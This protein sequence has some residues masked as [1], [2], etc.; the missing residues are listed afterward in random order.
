MPV[1]VMPPAAPPNWPYPLVAYRTAPSYYLDD[2]EPADVDVSGVHKHRHSIFYEG[3]TVALRIQKNTPTNWVVKAVLESVYGGVTSQVVTFG[4]FAPGHYRVYYTGSLTDP[5]YGPAYGVTHFSVLRLHPNFLDMRSLDSRYAVF[6]WKPNGYGRVDADVDAGTNTIGNSVGGFDMIL[7]NALSMP[8]GRTPIE[9]NWNQGPNGAFDMDGLFNNGAG[10]VDI[11]GRYTETKNFLAGVVDDY[12][13]HSKSSWADPHRQRDMWVNYPLYS[14]LYDS[15]A[16]PQSPAGLDWATIM[17]LN[18]SIDTSKLFIK[19]TAGTSSGRKITVYYPDTSTIVETYDNLDLQTQAVAAIN[20][21]GGSPT[22]TASTYIRIFGSDGAS[23]GVLST[24]TAFHESGWQ[25]NSDQLR[26]L[27]ANY[28]PLGCLRVEGPANEPGLSAFIAHAIMIADQSAQQG[29]SRVR[30]MGTCPVDIYHLTTPPNNRWTDVFDYWASVSY[31]P[32]VLSFHDYNSYVGDINLL[33]NQ[34]EAFRALR[35]QY[36]LESVELWQTEANS[37][38]IIINGLYLPAQTKQ[39]IVKVLLWE[40]YGLPREHNTHWYDA[41]VGFVSQ[42][43]WM[44]QGDQALMPFCVLWSVLGQETYAKPHHHRID[45]GSVQANHLFFGSLYGDPLTGSV[46]VLCANSAMPSNTVTLKVNNYTGALTVVDAVGS[47]S[48]V[49][50]DG[51]GLVTVE[52]PD[53]PSYLRLPAG[54]TVSVDHVRDH[55]H[56]PS[57]S[58]SACFL[59]TAVGGSPAA[60]LADGPFMGIYLGGKPTSGSTNVAFGTGTLPD[61]AVI[62]FAQS[63]A[64][65]RVLVYSC[66]AYQE[67]PA[68]LAYTI[69]TLGTDGVTWTTRETVTKSPPAS[70][71]FGDTHAGTSY[72][73]FWDQQYIEDV[74]LTG[75]PITCKGVRVNV[76]ALSYGGAADYN[77]NLVG[78][79]WGDSIAGPTL[80]LQR[81]SVISGTSFS[82]PGDYDTAVVADSPNAFWLLNES[83]GTS[84]AS[85]VNSPEVEGVATNVDWGATGLVPSKTDTSAGMSRGYIDVPVGP[86]VELGDRVALTRSDPTLGDG[87]IAAMDTALQTNSTYHFMITKNGSAVHIYINGVD[88]T[89][90]V[91]NLTCTDATSSDM[92]V[93]ISSVAVGASS[94]FERFAIYPT[95]LSAARAVAHYTAGTAPVAPAANGAAIPYIEGTATVGS[96][97]QASSYFTTDWLRSP[98]SYAYQWQS[99]TH[100]AGVWSSVGGE[101]RSDLIIPAS[102]SGKDLRVLVTP[103]NAG[104]AGSAV[105][106]NVVGPV[107]AAGKLSG[108]GGVAR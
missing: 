81:V 89:G 13:L 19:F 90:T 104:G 78:Q 22:T 5:D 44:Y 99:S 29:D 101:T 33:R 53:I 15:M 106:S 85:V 7:R 98:T 83:S 10:L 42:P 88:H 25:L 93:Q 1:P 35:K 18:G 58:V 32:A 46:A 107:A 77:A 17:P 2:N 28:A 95:A 55:D 103:S 65:E 11:G 75:G 69:D 94:N 49:T 71:L 23:A 54:V 36:G 66:P 87:P 64:V 62:T 80:S 59:T 38:P 31:T 51:S 73:S 41:P 48:T 86:K 6:N 105:A 60:V 27:A 39:G 97:L 76:T 91:T 40:Q 30:A 34:A 96:Q 16:L 108:F 3:D 24:P 4:T 47:K 8:P 72:E 26:T 43:H 74:K 82:S 84:V 21:G 12:Y 79:G 14:Q 37:S 20:T 45:F 70:L 50:P 68:L 9:G 61:S 102:V 67:M 63:F 92:G 56:N 57:P 52:V 100:G